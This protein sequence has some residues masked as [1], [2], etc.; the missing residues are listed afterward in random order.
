MNTREIAAE[1]RLAQWSQRMQERI[2][3]GESI[4]EFC[5]KHGISR[6]TYFYW[7]RKLRK[8]V[9]KQITQG[10]AE[11]VPQTP[12]PKGWMLCAEE[13]PE[14]KESVVTIEIGKCRVTAEKTTDPE[15]LSKVC[16][17]LVSI[18]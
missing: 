13:K 6:N 15:L 4:T 2:R 7:Q 18:C 1:Y 5:Q 12:V 17:R 8:T 10:S 16:R 11:V 9:I 14:S 3:N